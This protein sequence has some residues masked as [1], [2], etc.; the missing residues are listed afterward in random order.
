MARRARFSPVGS[1]AGSDNV[2]VAVR[3]GAARHRVRIFGQ[4]MNNITTYIPATHDLLHGVKGFGVRHLARR[5]LSSRTLRTRRSARRRLPC[6]AIA[7]TRWLAQSAVQLRCDRRR[8]EQGGPSARPRATRPNHSPP[9]LPFSSTR[10]FISLKDEGVMTIILPHRR[11][12]GGAQERIRPPL[13]QDGHR[14]TPR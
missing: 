14:S 2:R 12:L 10:R 13:Q 6:P 8:K 1:A 11:R 4:A 9:T 5:T 3:H 7:G